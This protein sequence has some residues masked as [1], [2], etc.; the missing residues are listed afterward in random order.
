MKKSIVNRDSND[1]TLDFNKE[2]Y[3]GLKSCWNPYSGL[4]K[5]ILYSETVIFCYR[6][7]WRLT[8]YAKVNGVYCLHVVVIYSFFQCEENQ[9]MEL[10]EANTK[11]CNG[12][13]WHNILWF[14]RHCCMIMYYMTCNV[15]GPTL[16]SKL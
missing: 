10:D 16:I 11:H 2:W 8:F 3:S 12:S 5:L 13:N 7:C 1:V 15:C 9:G 4:I 6:L 14:F